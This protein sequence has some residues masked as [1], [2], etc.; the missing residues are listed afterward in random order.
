MADYVYTVVPSR[1]SELLSKIR[2]TGIPTKKVTKEWLDALGFK[3]K[4]DYTLLRVLKFIQFV[5]TSSFPS[6]LWKDY[7]GANYKSVLAK[8][9]RNGYA[10][11]FATYPDAHIRGNK[12]LEDF[13]ATKSSLG[14]STISRAI[15][16]FKAL[17]ALADFS[18]VNIVEDINNNVIEPLVQSPATTYKPDTNNKSGITININIQLSLPETKDADVYDLLFLSLKKHLLNGGHICD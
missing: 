7:R 17:C 13:F 2:E 18:A 4:N 15:T 9:I 16:T 12:D 10:D 8:G 6:D 5:D 1:I 11:L 14:K 3:S